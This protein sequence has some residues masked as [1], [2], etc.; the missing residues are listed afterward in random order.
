[1]IDF[2]Y[3]LLLLPGKA[4]RSLKPVN[5]LVVGTHADCICAGNNS[6]ELTAA[7]LL[8]AI[9]Q[10]FDD[11]VLGTKMFSVNALEA[12]SSEMKALRGALSEL[13]YNICQVLNTELIEL[14]VVLTFCFMV[15]IHIKYKNHGD[16]F[17]KS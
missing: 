5:V 8:E 17:K 1:M 7:K 4:G 12:M 16:K 9:S 2:L 14:Q 13:K 6:A 15:A 11:L 3:V 10:K